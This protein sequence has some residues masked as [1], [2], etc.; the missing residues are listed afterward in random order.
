MID[1][2]TGKPV[3]CSSASAHKEYETAVD[4]ILGS[5]TG[6]AE[7]LDRALA[8]DP[9]H[10][11]AAVARYLVARD[12][13]EPDA[14]PF[15]AQAIESSRAASDWERAHVE[16]LVALLEDPYQALASTEAYIKGNPGDLLIISQLCGYLIFYGGPTKLTRVL[17][18]LES[19]QDPLKDDWAYLSRLGFAASEAGDVKRGRALVERALA[20][21]PQ[22]LYSIHALAHVLHDAG[23][24]EE[25]ARQLARWLDEHGQGARGGQLYG[26]VQWHLAL[27]RQDDSARPGGRGSCP[28]VCRHVGPSI[29]RAAC[30]RPVCVRG[31]Y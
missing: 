31:G 27:D 26:H 28:A 2:R 22:A 3:T 14:D 18:I 9:H 16:T 30:G 17:D 7:H 19:V 4:L 1:Q 23:E 10:A 13:K 6:A 12:A 11:L 29:H 24:A 20:I 8:L 15:K 25:S 5:E 21:R